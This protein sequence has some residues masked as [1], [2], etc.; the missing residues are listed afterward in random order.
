MGGFDV[1]NRQGLIARQEV[2][3]VPATVVPQPLF[4]TSNARPSSF[5]SSHPSP[6]L[7]PAVMIPKHLLVDQCDQEEQVQRNVVEDYL[8]IGRGTKGNANA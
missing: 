7:P 5:L 3:P 8:C 6:D 2:R 4:P 1:G